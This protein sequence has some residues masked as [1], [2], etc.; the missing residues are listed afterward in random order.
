MGS[1][2]KKPSSSIIL[3][4]AS[5]PRRANSLRSSLA[6]STAVRSWPG[7]SRTYS[8]AIEPFADPLPVNAGHDD[9]GQPGQKAQVGLDNLLDA[10][11]THFE[12]DFTAIG[13]PHLFV[14]RMR[15]ISASASRQSSA[16]SPPA[17]PRFSAR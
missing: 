6:A 1:A 3:S 14:V 5:V 10:G 17:K 4:T 8:L 2:W 13:Q 12:D 9:F 11:P 16:V 7:M 15:S